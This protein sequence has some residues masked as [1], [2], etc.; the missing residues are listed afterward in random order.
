MVFCEIS[1]R[2]F[3]GFKVEV[4]LNYMDT[5]EQICDQVK[6]SLI[7]TL[8]TNNLRSL[9]E[10]AKAITFHVHDLEFGSILLMQN[11]DKIWICNHS[12]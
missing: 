5:I 7:T 3:G 11:D 10:K 2:L 9:V 12:H 4:D 8:Q 1:C 6:T